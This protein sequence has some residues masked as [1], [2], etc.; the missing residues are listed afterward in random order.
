MLDI[1]A[2]LGWMRDNNISRFGGDPSRV[3]IFGQ[4]GGG[5]KVSTLM[6]MPAAKGSSIAPLSRAAR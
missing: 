4:S 1:V 5:G 6:A 3:T 2:A